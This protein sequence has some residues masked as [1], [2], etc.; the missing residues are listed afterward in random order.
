MGSGDQE[1]NHLCPFLIK[2]K[3][4][5]AYLYLNMYIGFG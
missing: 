2:S 4:E 5:V 3:G 1:P